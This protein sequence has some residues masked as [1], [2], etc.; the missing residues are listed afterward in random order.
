VNI[1]SYS[2]N[3]LSTIAKHNPDAMLE[4]CEKISNLADEAFWELKT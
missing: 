2:I 3:M 4:V 1:R